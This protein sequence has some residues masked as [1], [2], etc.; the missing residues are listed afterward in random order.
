MMKMTSAA[1]QSFFMAAS[2]NGRWP[3]GNLIKLT[4]EMPINMYNNQDEEE[5]SNTQLLTAIR[6]YQML[7]WPCEPE[8]CILISKAS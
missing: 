4:L 5:I 3:K 7:E 1:I 8:Q 2:S 6:N